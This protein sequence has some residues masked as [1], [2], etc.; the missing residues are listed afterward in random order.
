MGKEHLAI[1]NI[2]EIQKVKLG[3]KKQIIFYATSFAHWATSRTF[4]LMQS[5]LGIPLAGILLLGILLLG[6]CDR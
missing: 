5:V 1:Y 4:I 3:I 2:V 6:I